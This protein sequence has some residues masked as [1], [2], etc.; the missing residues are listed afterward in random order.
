MRRQDRAVVLAGTHGVPAQHAGPGR[1]Q[2]G[3]LAGLAD[4]ADALAQTARDGGELVL[5]LLHLGVELR[6]DQRDGADRGQRLEQRLVGLVEGFGL[7]APGHAQ[8]QGLVPHVHGGGQLVVARRADPERGV[9]R[10]EQVGGRVED[11]GLR[12]VGPHAAVDVERGLEQPVQPG[13]VVAGVEG[14]RADQPQHDGRQHG[15]GQVPRVL[16]QEESGRDGDADAT[17]RDEDLALNARDMTTR[18]HGVPR[19]AMIVTMD[20]VFTTK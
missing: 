5:L 8:P 11:G 18:R 7:A 10:T 3:D 2:E 15:D 19:V 17:G 12:L 4:G 9:G 20:P 16:G 1:V 6:V 13:P 14:A